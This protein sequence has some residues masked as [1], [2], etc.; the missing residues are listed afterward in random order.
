M[1]R[2][3]FRRDDNPRAIARRPERNRL[4]DAT[5]GAGDEESLA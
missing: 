5:A 3:G 4:P 1:W 2:L